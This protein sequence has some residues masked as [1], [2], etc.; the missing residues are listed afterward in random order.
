MLGLVWVMGFGGGFGFWC[1]GSCGG[2]MEKR[3]IWWF[4]FWVLLRYWV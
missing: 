4:G 1:G 2:G 3:K